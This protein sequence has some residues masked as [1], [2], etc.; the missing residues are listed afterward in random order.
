MFK[1]FLAV[2]R[3]PFG[4]IETV[5]REM[6]QQDKQRGFRELLIQNRFFHQLSTNSVCICKVWSRK[7]SHSEKHTVNNTLHLTPWQY[8]KMRVE[9]RSQQAQI[10]F[11]FSHQFTVLMPN[12]LDI[13]HSPI[14]VIVKVMIVLYLYQKYCRD[15]I[16]QLRHFKERGVITERHGL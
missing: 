4:F 12:I 7:L 11:Y 10:I 14:I 2:I 13:Y 6:G 5:Q 3:L 9:C 1:I 16:V 15:V 8:Q